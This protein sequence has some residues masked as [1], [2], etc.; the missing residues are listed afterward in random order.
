MCFPPLSERRC[1]DEE[2]KGKLHPVSEALGRAADSASNVA[3]SASNVR[4][5]ASFSLKVIELNGVLKVYIIQIQTPIY[6]KQANG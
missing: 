6:K 2:Y 4:G 1:R 3:D 5:Q